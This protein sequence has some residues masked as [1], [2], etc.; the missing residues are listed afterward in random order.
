M[1]KE[2]T[3]ES[4]K[5]MGKQED[6]GI[7]LCWEVPAGTEFGIDCHISM[8]GSNFKGF[9]WIP[10]NYPHFIYFAAGAQDGSPTIRSGF[11]VHFTTP[12]QVIVKLWSNETEEFLAD[13]EQNELKQRL[14]HAVVE[15]EFDPFLGTYPIEQ[16]Q[17][18]GYF[19]K[20]FIS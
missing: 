6:G 13:N 5:T 1:L 10:L 19:G 12:R 7:L 16:L 20:S 17:K 8:T 4:V 15:H 3:K 2:R 9:K 11:W 14:E 18:W